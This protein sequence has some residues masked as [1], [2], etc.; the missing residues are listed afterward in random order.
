MCCLDA[1]AENARP[2]WTFSAGAPVT[3]EMFLDSERGAL[4]FSS[5]D[6]RLWALSMKTG[7]R[8]WKSPFHG[9]GHPVGPPQPGKGKVYFATVKAVYALDSSD[10]SLVWKFEPPDGV[11]GGL[12]FDEGRLFVGSRSGR[13]YCFEEFD[14]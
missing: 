11:S 2:R 7:A 14:G 5:D 3:R 1:E 6:G 9:E 12:C 8:L 4:Y 10:A 13:V